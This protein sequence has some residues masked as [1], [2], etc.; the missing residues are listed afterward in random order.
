MIVD[1]PLALIDANE[2]NRSVGDLSPMVESIGKVGLLQPP[3]LIRNGERYRV[4]AGHRRLAAVALLGWK[5]CRCSVVD[6]STNVALC[7]L[8]EN[9]ARLDL[10]PHELV[11]SV[12]AVVESGER[13]KD[14]AEGLGLS[15]SYIR[16]LVA[17]R[18]RLIPEAW[19][20]FEAQGRKAK[21]ADFIG[22]A[23]RPPVVQL[24]TIRGE[25]APERIPQEKGKMQTR[26]TISAKHAKLRDG[27]PRKATLAWVLGLAPWPEFTG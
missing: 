17:V 10:A 1:I 7:R 23:Y 22:L 13:V 15:V 18:T 5:E 27:D 3:V 20:L 19:A 26:L 9:V 2:N 25:K 11:S 16:N 6:P 12:T 21:I 8:I 4:V 14:V 24:A